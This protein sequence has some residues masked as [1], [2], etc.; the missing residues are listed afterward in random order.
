MFQRQR[1][2]SNETALFEGEIMPQ[3]LTGIS[4]LKAR[5]LLKD[6]RG[7]PYYYGLRVVVEAPKEPAQDI[8]NLVERAF[9][10]RGIVIDRPLRKSLYDHKRRGKN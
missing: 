5:V 6:E 8:L 2:Q 9:I 10:M 4:Q 1:A 3:L 7:D